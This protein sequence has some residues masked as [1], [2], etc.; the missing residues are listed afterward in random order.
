MQNGLKTLIYCTQY[1]PFGQ[2]EPLAAVELE[3]LSLYF[4]KVVVV[5]FFKEA[6]VREM[7]SNAEL[8]WFEKK[9]SYVPILGDRGTCNLFDPFWEAIRNGEGRMPMVKGFSAKLQAAK[10]HAER[11]ISSLNIDGS[12]VF[13][14]PW[15]DRWGAVFSVLKNHLPEGTARFAVRANGADLYPDRLPPFKRHIQ[16]LVFGNGIQVFPVSEHGRN[17]LNQFR[18]GFPGKTVYH[19]T[20]DIGLNPMPT[21]HHYHLLTC[22]TLQPVK[23]LDKLPGLLAALDVPFKWTHIG[24]EGKE[25]EALKSSAINLLGAERVSFKGRLNRAQIAEFYQTQPVDLFLNISSSEGLPLAVVEA[26]SAGIPI[27]LSPVGAWEELLNDSF[28]QV[29]P[30]DFSSSPQQFAETITHA[31]ATYS[32]N[33][34]ARM[35]AR[36]HWEANFQAAVNYA[37]F[38]SLLIGPSFKGYALIFGDNLPAYSLSDELLMYGLPADH[39]LVYSATDG[40]LK[41][42]EFDFQFIQTEEDLRERIRTTI[43]PISPYP[44][45]EG[46]LHLLK[47]L[48]QQYSNVLDPCGL[49]FVPNYLLKDVQ[50]EVSKSASVATV[51]HIRLENTDQ[52][53]SFKLPFW[54]KPADKHAVGYTGP[55]LWKVSTEDELNNALPEIQQVLA[56]HTRLVVCEHVGGSVETLVVYKSTNGNRLTSFSARRLRCYPD[57]YSL[58]SLVEIEY[59]KDLQ[60]KGRKLARSFPFHGILEFE[61]IRTEE[62]RL[63]FLEC[64]PRSTSWIGADRVAGFQ[65]AVLQW[66]DLVEQSADKAGKQSNKKGYYVHLRNELLNFSLG[67]LHFKDLVRF[68]FKNFNTLKA[69]ETRALPDLKMREGVSAIKSMVYRLV[70]NK[71]A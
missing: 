28:G 1:Y 39:I 29:L 47:S 56:Q 19:G 5:P 46:H 68:L 53:S 2:R 6:G 45:T 42:S 30:A 26:E 62:G 59:I 36:L 12:A 23:Q 25:L 24:G 21:D 58:F 41:K 18:Q 54:V 3:Y 50:S 17:A 33:A 4:D 20:P 57:D 43:G 22:S 31:L 63:L 38:A 15:L 35:A 8:L 49:E 40:P 66:Q 71:S 16:N 65:M 70:G 64:N 51:K 69:Y 67:R 7:P 37:S 10:I 32:R 14:S 61:F 11:L 60:D 48:M 9:L 55:R 44:N 27:V 34:E 13:Y 52:L